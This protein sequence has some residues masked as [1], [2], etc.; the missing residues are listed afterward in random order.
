MG[1]TITQAQTTFTTTLLPST[2]TPIIVDG[3]NCSIAGCS[4]SVSA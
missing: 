3:G 1:T 2:V 4:E